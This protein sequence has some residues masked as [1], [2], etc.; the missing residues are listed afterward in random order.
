MKRFL[1]SGLKVRIGG[2]IDLENKSDPTPYIFGHKNGGDGRMA[3]PTRN[4]TTTKW[5]F[6]FDYYVEGKRK[7]VRRR[8]F[9]TQREANKAMISLQK[10][11]QNDEYVQNNQQK[12]G[13]FVTYWLD[14][15]R[16][17]ECDDTTF[18]NNQLLL[19]NHIIPRIGDIKLQHLDPLTCQKF[20]KGMHDDGYARNTIERVA[21]LIKQALD[22]AI[23]YKYMKENHMRKVTLPKKLKR[24]LNVWTIDQVNHFLNFTRTRRYYC[25]YALALLAGMRQGEILGLRWKDIDFEKK[26]IAINQTLTHYG[27]SLSHGA[28]TISGNRT[29][30]IPSQLVEV[31]R[32]QQKDYEALKQRLGRAFEDIDIV[33]FNLKNGKTIYPSNLTKTWLKDVKEAE[34][35]RIRFHDMRHTHATMLIQRNVNVKIISERLGHSKSSITLDVYSHVIPSMQLEL[36]NTI[37]DMITL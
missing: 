16:K 35:P 3:T 21:T 12:V 9:D 33:I 4:P 34:L 14:H 24:E 36:A 26:T 8:G 27:K 31:L 37:E 23:I 25:V 13:P 10:E 29:I 11:V 1:I 5:D 32:R 6:V 28:K 18:Y 22:T 2:V 17:L 20:I 7:Q 30:S 15:V 19:K